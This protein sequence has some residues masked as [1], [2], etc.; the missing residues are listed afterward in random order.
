MKITNA[1]AILGSKGGSSRSDA[2]QAAA[3]E[4]G[5]LGGRP[6]TEYHVVRLDYGIRNSDGNYHQTHHFS[7]HRTLDAAVNSV[8]K[9]EKSYNCVAIVD[10]SGKKIKFE[11][12]QD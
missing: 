10:Q 7:N 2:K 1:A 8:M 4:N 12:P 3:R 9:T 5:K 6:R 11:Y